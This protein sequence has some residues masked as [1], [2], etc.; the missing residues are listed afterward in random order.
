MSDLQ[1]KVRD[2]EADAKEALRK[3]DGNE[4]LG[5]RAANIGDRLGNA[6][7]DTGDSVHKEADE[8]SRDAAYEAG[9]KDGTMGPR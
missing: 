3:A 1:R 9:R 6:A 5:D 4:S 7:K 2:T 8:L